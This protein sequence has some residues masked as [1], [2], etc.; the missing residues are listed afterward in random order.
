MTLQKQRNPS[1]L[2]H[3]KSRQ[4]I[5]TDAGR[6]FLFAGWGAYCQGKIKEAVAHTERS[7]VLHPEMGEVFFHAFNVQ[8]VLGDVES[9]LRMLAKAIDIDRFYALKAAG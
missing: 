5:R 1:S 9:G 8:M 4:I 7:M 2:P 3:A 6:A